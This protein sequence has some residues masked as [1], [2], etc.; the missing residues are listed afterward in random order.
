MHH[1]F[2]VN[3]MASLLNLVK[4]VSDIV[5]PVIEHVIALLVL[6][7]AHNALQSVDLGCDSFV[8]DHVSNFLLSQVNTHSYYLS[9]TSKSDPAVV[10][11]DDSDVVLNQLPQ[12][13]LKVSFG[14]LCQVLFEW[15]I[16]FHLSFNLH[17]VKWHYLKG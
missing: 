11:L 1:L 3:Q 10:L 12:V 9:Q 2:P 4:H 5:V 7:E 6:Q 17:V 14:M 13:L 15:F 16:C 8:H